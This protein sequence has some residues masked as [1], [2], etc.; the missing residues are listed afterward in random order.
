M[1]Y[2]FNF[3][4]YRILHILKDIVEKDDTHTPD[5]RQKDYLKANF[6]YER[7]DMITE[8]QVLIYAFPQSNNLF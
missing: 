6:P 2:V 5:Y 8:I 7:V 3:T 4:L 1:F